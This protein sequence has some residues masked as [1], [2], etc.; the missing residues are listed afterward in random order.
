MDYSTLEKRRAACEAEVEINR[1][2]APSLYLGTIPITR[3]EG[4]LSLGGHGQ[5]VEWAV[6]MR[7]FDERNTLD[8]VAASG[9]LTRPVLGKMVHAI[10]ASHASAPR[11]DAAAATAALW[12]YLEQ[13]DRAFREWPNLFPEEDVRGPTERSSAVLSK[14][15]PL[16]RQRG[17]MGHIRRC[18]GDLHLRNLV[19]LDGEP[20][21]FDAVEFDESIA[22]GDVLY[23]LAFLLMDLWDRGL[24]EPANFVLNRYL[25]ES[26]EAHL[27]GLAAMPLFLSLRAAIRAKVVAAGLPH[28]DRKARRS[29]TAKAVR[30]LK[31]AIGFLEP[32]RPRAAFQVPARA[33]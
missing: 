10:V 6:H 21:L 3:A 1:K 2:T 27:S 17:D 12:R 25:W 28:L 20:T 19:L 14:L 18:H 22:T 11:R 30:Y 32:K 7:R 33:P 8:H 24:R 16:L 4:S 23:D 26:D 9:G 13:N 5:P 29:A 31:S 15:E